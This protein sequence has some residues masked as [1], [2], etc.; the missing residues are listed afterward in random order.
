M[1]DPLFLHQVKEDKKDKH[2]NNKSDRDRKKRD[3]VSKNPA[4]QQIFKNGM[5]E[6]II[7]LA[8]LHKDYPNLLSNNCLICLD[9]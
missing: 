5:G 7:K 1:R 9:Y 8:Y 6:K 3:R 2:H 4:I